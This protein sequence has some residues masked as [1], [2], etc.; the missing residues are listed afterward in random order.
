MCVSARD[1]LDTP[2]NAT[3]ALQIGVR[4]GIRILV[5]IASLH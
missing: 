5:R 4:Q 1:F 2:P 3:D